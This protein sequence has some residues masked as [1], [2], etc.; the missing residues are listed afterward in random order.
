MTKPKTAR[1]TAYGVLL[2][3]EKTRSYANLLLAQVLK[4]SPLDQR[5]KGLA[6]ELVY[7]TLRA[8][9]T[10]DW[11]LQERSKTKLQKLDAPVRIIL[12]LGAY[13]LLFTRVPTAIACFETVELAKRYCHVGSV[14]YVNAVLRRLAK[15]KDQLR[16]PDPQTEP[17]NYIAVKHSHPRWLVER[18]LKRFGFKDTEALCTANNLAPPLC[19]RTNNTLTSKEQL[20]DDL[21]KGGYEAISGR[22]MPEAIYLT[23]GGEVRQ[24]PGFINGLFSVQDESSMFVARALTPCPNEHIL[25]VCAG[26]GGKT[27]HLAEIM[28]GQGQITA[29]DVHRHKLDLIEKS[30]ERLKLK[31]IRFWEGDAR[32]LPTEY[33]QSFQRVLVD[34]PCSGTGVLRRRAD[35]RWHKTPTELAQ[36]PKLQLDIL[37]G[38]ASAVRSDGI[39]VYSTCS[40]E[41]EENGKVI[42]AFL[43]SR[44]D[45]ILDDL[46][47]VLKPYIK[48]PTLKQGWLQLYPH[49]HGTDGFFLARLKKVSRS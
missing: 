38:A 3:V 39:L 14:R 46:T 42:D 11:A 44:N 24:V 26:P 2:R 41:P 40:L 6:T 21:S 31:G 25:D 10:I 48:E 1:D 36:L 32:H 19:L 30:A 27:T 5:D 29:V 12:R 47:D 43:A 18:W 15:D 13:Q 33:A 49:K 20:M 28:A 16:Y 35:L 8:Q 7:G 23:G 34:A 9:G 37:I 22:F 4:Q 45:F 17:V